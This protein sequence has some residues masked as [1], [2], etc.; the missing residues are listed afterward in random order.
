MKK[1]VPIL[2]IA[3]CVCMSALPISAQTSDNAAG[4]DEAGRLNAQAVAL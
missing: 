4:S 1:S 3:M 2:P